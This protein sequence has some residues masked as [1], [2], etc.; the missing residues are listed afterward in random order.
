MDVIAAIKEKEADDR[1]PFIVPM[2]FRTEYKAGNNGEQ[3]PEDWV[4]WIKKGTQNP[5]VIECK[6]SRM[7]RYYTAEW[8]VLEPYYL[9]WKE[10][11][12]APVDGTALAAWPGATPQLVKAMEPYHI[13]SVEDLTQLEDASISKIA[14]PGLRNKVMQAKAFLE[15]QKN[16]AGV[17]AEVTKLRDDNAFLRSELEAMRANIAEL[18]AQQSRPQQPDIDER[19]PMPK[20]RGWPAGKPRKPQPKLDQESI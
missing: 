2:D 1:K 14:I 19:I 11:Q 12:S 8:G 3:I 7:P 13:R 6:I 10:G 20:K 18:S 9:R 16:V 15:A 4:S 5:P 17:S